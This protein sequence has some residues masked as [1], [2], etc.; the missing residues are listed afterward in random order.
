MNENLTNFIR[1]DPVSL[2]NLYSQYHKEN[3]IYFDYEY[4]QNQI[5]YI[6][7]AYIN[8]NLIC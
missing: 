6:C 3:S 1:K 4:S 7:K 2:L 8:G 5:N